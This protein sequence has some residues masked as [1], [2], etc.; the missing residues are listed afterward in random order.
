MPLNKDWR[1]FVELLHSN[2][3]EG[4]VVGG[5]LPTR[6]RLTTCPTDYHRYSAILTVSESGRV[7]EDAPTQNL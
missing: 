7:R 3:V 5:G 1:E 4:L 6:R 2:G